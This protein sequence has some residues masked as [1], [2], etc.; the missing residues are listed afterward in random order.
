MSQR[1][2]PESYRV[3]AGGVSKPLVTRD[4]VTN[5]R[6]IGCCLSCGT[7]AWPLAFSVQSIFILHSFAL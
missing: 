1:N 5:F 2:D 3:R 6:E 4:A 7:Q